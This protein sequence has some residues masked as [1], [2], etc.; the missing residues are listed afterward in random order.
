MYP[1]VCEV[2]ANEDF[3]LSMTLDNGEKRILDMKPYLDFGI[4]K[5]IKNYENFKSARVVFDT[6][7]WHEGIDLDPEFIIAK[8]KAVN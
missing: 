7:E 2:I 5:K 3:T 4:F 1:G 6:I 8:S